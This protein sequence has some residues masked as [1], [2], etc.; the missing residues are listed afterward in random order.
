V[1]KPLRLAFFG[2]P[3]FAVPSLTHLLESAHQVVA[4]VTQP[5]RPRGRGQRL[6]PSPVKALAVARGVPVLQPERLRGAEFADAFAAFSPDLAVVAAYGKILPESLL[7]IPGLGMINVHASLLP[8]WRG[9]APIHRAILTGD[10]ETGVTIMRVVRELDAG[11]MLD[12]RSTPIGPDETSQELES[13]LAAIGADV[14]MSVVGRLAVGPIAEEPQDEGLVTYAGR[15]ERRESSVDWR[16]PARVV[17]NQIRGLQP[18]P[19]ASTGWRGKR[20]VLKRAGLA[21]PAAATGTP[22]ESA[23]GTIRAIGDVGLLVTTGTGW[24]WIRELQMAGAAPVAARAW[25]SGQRAQPGDR[26]VTLP[27]APA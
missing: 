5:D 22:A 14:L 23:P 27:V 10:S 24:L 19:Q 17:H 26:F 11:P 18:W 8:R 20:V 16:A 9:A 21:D 3:A 15:L 25:A 6:T 4:V 13:R 12:R 7:R 2:T 1:V